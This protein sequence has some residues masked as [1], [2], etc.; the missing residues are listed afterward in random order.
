[1]A[2]TESKMTAAVNAVAKRVNLTKKMGVIAIKKAQEGLK[3][4]LDALK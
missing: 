2:E 4:V 1:M 3:G